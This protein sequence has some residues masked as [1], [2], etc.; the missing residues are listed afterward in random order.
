MTSDHQPALV[1]TSE[2]T[3]ISRIYSS[4]KCYLYL[5]SF[6]DCTSH[7]FS[8]SVNQNKT[9]LVRL[10]STFIIFFWKWRGK[11]NWCP[12]SNGNNKEPEG[13][14]RASS[15]SV[16]LHKKAKFVD[17]SIHIIHQSTCVHHFSFFKQSFHKMSRDIHPKTK[18]SCHIQ[19]V[20]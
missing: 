17:I 2:A 14:K 3:H 8:L 11:T 9:T 19:A 4:F 6:A 18:C 7:C 12:F 15:S 16:N 10:Q 5:Y 20:R 1:I 13:T